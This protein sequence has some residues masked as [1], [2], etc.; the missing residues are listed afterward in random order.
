MDYVTS[1]RGVGVMYRDLVPLPGETAYRVHVV[2]FTLASLRLVHN[3]TV[4]RIIAGYT[5][6]RISTGTIPPFNQY[7][8]NIPA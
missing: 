2:V 6:G 7:D 5:N 4:M 8:E 3:T 1:P